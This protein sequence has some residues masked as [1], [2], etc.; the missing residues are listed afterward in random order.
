MIY[1]EAPMQ[2][3]AA[4][5][6]ESAADSLKTVSKW[7][8]ESQLKEL[9]SFGDTRAQALGATGVTP[10]FQKG[11]ELGLQTARTIIAGSP[12]IMLK[13]IKPEDVL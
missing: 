6:I 11:Y 9:Q 8:R 13:G 1:H 5:F 7:L 12:A 3:P 10:D 4:M 2:S